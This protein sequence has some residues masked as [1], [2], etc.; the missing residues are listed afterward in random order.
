MFHFV[1]IYWL[2]GEKTI[3]ASNKNNVVDLNVKN[4]YEFITVPI[5]IDGEKTK[6][7]KIMKKQTMAIGLR[8]KNTGLHIVHPISSFILSWKWRTRE[9]NTKRKHSTNIVKFLNYLLQD[10]KNKI[11]SLAELDIAT[12]NAY[13]NSLTN[14][15][16]KRET[17]TDAARTLTS[18][19]VWLNRNDCLPNVEDNFIDNST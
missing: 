18:F 17:I 1:H 15:H 13:L 4:N 14:D 11:K 16:R 6:D 7:S 3:N 19:Y 12:G 8:N 10:K 2:K 9:F 5:W